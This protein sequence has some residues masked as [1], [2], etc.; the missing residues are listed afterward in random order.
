MLLATNSTERM[1]INTNGAMFFCSDFNSTTA[2]V[3][4]EVDGD[5]YVTADGGN[6]VFMQID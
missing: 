3:R 1:R 4:V 5:T 6:V 2:G